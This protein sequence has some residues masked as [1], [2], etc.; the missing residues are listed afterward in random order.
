MCGDHRVGVT[1]LAPL[2]LET[3]I[4]IKR[5]EIDQILI[6]S[7]SKYSS[8]LNTLEVAKKNSLNW[9]KRKFLRKFPG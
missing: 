5:T 9:P 2:D 3:K 4:K 7:V 8:I 1:H 6:K